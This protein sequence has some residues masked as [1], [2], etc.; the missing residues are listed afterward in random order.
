MLPK[1]CPI[2]DNVKRRLQNVALAQYLSYGRSQNIN[3]KNPLC[4]LICL[5]GTLGIAEEKYQI[6]PSVWG[7]EK[8]YGGYDFYYKEK[9][10]AEVRP[11]VWGTEK[12]PGGYEL[13]REERKTGGAKASVWGQDKWYGGYEIKVA[14]E[15][16]AT[17]LK[18]E[19]KIK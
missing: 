7:T 13:Y 14:N 4:L 16:D 18:R 6:R 9:K 10:A 2:E 5:F 19:L 8:W 17:Y 3:M 12:W 1:P 11:S 15:K